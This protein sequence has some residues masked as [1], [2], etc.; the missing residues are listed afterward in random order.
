MEIGTRSKKYDYALLHCSVDRH[1]DHLTVRQLGGN[2][3][4]KLIGAFLTLCV[5]QAGLQNELV[6]F[7]Q[8]TLLDYGLMPAY[9][10]KLSDKRHHL[11][12]DV[13]SWDGNSGT[14]VMLFEGEVVGLHVEVANAL[15]EQLDRDQVIY[16]QMQDVAESL[17]AA[18]ASTPQAGVALLCHVFA[19]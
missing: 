16:H 8:D 2:S 9:G 13:R 7:R 18:A 3:T 11:L 14:A 12:Y 5:F 1:S 4:D 15:M 17:A 10:C 19:K 6:D